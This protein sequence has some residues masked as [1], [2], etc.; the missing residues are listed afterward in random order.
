MRKPAKRGFKTAY[1]YRNAPERLAD[2]VAVNNNGSV[3]AQS[4]FSAGR[5]GVRFPSVFRNGVVRN[6]GIDIT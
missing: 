5:V 4:R 1:N 3:G 6:H 2:F